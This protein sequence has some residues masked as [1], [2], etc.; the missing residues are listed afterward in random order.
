MRTPERGSCEDDDLSPSSVITNDMVEGF[1]TGRNV[2]R[3]ASVLPVATR[4]PSIRAITLG[5]ATLRVGVGS[6]MLFH[7]SL[8]ARSLG[9]D[10]VTAEQT[11]WVSTMI[12][13]RDLV[14]G[15]GVLGALRGDSRV[16]RTWLLACAAADAT[17]GLGIGRAVRRGSV[18]RLMGSLV[19]ASAV[20]AA[21]AGAAGALALAR[22]HD[23]AGFIGRHWYP[24]RTPAVPPRV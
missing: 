5:V 24:C 1:P 19:V 4:L 14:L 3:V 15:L 2:V 23:R 7:P 18:S 22:D 16:L 17:D 8:L 11:S 12:G 13:G 20:S 6:V 10:R 21:G 9:V